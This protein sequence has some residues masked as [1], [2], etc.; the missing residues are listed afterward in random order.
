MDSRHSSSSVSANHRRL[1]FVAVVGTALVVRVMALNGFE[2]T[3]AAEHPMVDAYTYWQQ[4]L[5]L[6]DGRDPFAEGYYQP[7][8]YPWLLARAGGW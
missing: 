6:L 5:S 8:A 3:L 4:A 7:P 1:A 2:T